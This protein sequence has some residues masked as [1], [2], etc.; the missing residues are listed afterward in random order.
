MLPFV[1]ALTSLLAAFSFAAADTTEP[2]DTPEPTPGSVSPAEAAA[3]RLAK[4]ED[5]GLDAA[6]LQ[7]GP[8]FRGL[9][10]A[11]SGDGAAASRVHSTSRQ[12][13]KVHPS[14]LDAAL[15]LTALL[16]SGESEGARL[17]F[18][19]DSVLMRGPA[20]ACVA[21]YSYLPC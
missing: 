15:Q 9:T 12:G 19:V 1:E 16:S 21:M 6:G 8:S 20:A 18:A 10:Q 3:A 14:E 2:A 4:E 13:T 5:A 7:Y 17:P 11:W